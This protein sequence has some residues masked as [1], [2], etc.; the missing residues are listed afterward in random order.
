[1]GLIPYSEKRLNYVVSFYSDRQNG[2]QDAITNG[3]ILDETAKDDNVC[4]MRVAQR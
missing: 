1:M 2:R 4:K 3:D